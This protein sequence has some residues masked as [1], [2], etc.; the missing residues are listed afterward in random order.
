MPGRKFDASEPESRRTYAGSDCLLRSFKSILLSPVE[1]E[2]VNDVHA[3]AN[4][5]CIVSPGL[6]I[7]GTAIRGPV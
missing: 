2:E 7:I 4:S 6:L 1:E 5:L 3:T